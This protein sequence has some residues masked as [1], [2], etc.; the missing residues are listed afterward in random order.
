MIASGG[1]EFPKWRD[2]Y[3]YFKKWSEKPNGNKESI[4]EHVLKK[5]IATKQ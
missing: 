4:L 2:C 3:D 5:I 1:K